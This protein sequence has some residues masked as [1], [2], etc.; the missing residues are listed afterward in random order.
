MSE[1]RGHFHIAHTIPGRIRVRLHHPKPHPSLMQLLKKEISTKEGI[2]QVIINPTTG[3]VIINYDQDR[4]THQDMMAILGEIGLVFKDLM[5]EGGP[6]LP[7][8]A[9]LESN[10]IA[11]QLAKGLGALDQ[12]ICART[13]GK[14]NLRLLVPVL[15]AGLGVRQI[16]KK[17]W[18]LSEVPGYVLIWYAF[19][20]F[21][22]FHPEI[23]HLPTSSKGSSPEPQ[24]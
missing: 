18:G 6:G 22:K 2:Y 17:G 10:S 23:V 5:T 16:M 7:G 11:K 19:D 14:A 4:C 1:I 15:M 3:S 21:Y 20:A 12:Q 8:K 9:D 24:N 13:G